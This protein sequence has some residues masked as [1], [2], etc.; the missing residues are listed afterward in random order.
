MNVSARSESRWTGGG[1]AGLRGAEER[2]GSSS[3]S[4]RG[5]GEGRRPAGPEKK[6][7]TGKKMSCAEN[8]RG[9]DGAWVGGLQQAED[10]SEE[11]SPDRK[12]R[13][14]GKVCSNVGPDWERAKGGESGGPRERRQI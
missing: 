3:P 1:L 4:P 9:E 8:K 11:T 10:A 12:R 7:P 5:P 2:K 6:N 14:E 13:E